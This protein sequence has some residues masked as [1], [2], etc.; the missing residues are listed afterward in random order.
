MILV[1]I[2]SRTYEVNDMETADKC[3]E[4]FNNFFGVRFHNQDSFESYMEECGIDFYIDCD[5]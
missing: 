5:F 3:R 2:G 1:N 4:I